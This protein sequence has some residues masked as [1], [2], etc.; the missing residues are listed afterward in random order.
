MTFTR[1]DTIMGA[2]AVSLIATTP[3]S[4]ASAQS[5]AQNANEQ[6]PGVYR[7]KIGKSLLTCVSDGSNSFPRSDGFVSNVSAAQVAKTLEAAFLPTD[8]ITLTFTPVVLD[9]AGRVVVIDTGLGEA[10][11]RSSKGV[12]GQFH[13]NLAAAGYDAKKVDQVLITHFHADHIGGLL[14]EDGKSSFPN[15]EIWV[16][17]SELAFWMDEGNA[18]RASTDVVRTN[19]ARAKRVMGALKSQL[20][21]YEPDKEVAPG[22]TSVATPGHTPGHSSFIVASDGQKVIIQGDA[23]T[24]PALFVE[25]PSWHV[26]SDMDP[27]VAEASRRK[28]YEMASAEKILIQGFHFDFPTLGR[29]AKNGNDYRFVPEGWKSTL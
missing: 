22:V 17:A 9:V 8:R 19:F 10:A 13:T 12:G 4:S 23:T 21:Q 14:S 3:G 1:R 15:S 16:P 7:R 24:H 2:A 29:V 28:L 20:K 11:F 18:A 25:R 26:W 27:V 6:V 5:A